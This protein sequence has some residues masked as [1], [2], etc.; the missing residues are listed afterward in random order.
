MNYSRMNVN[1]SIYIPRMSTHWTETTIRQ[2]MEACYIGTVA[3]VDFTPINKKPGFGENVDNVVMSAFV[4]FSEPVLRSD[5]HYYFESRVCDATKAFWTAIQRG[6]PYKMNVGIK[7]YWICLKNKNPIQRTM[8]NIHQ[9][10][11][12]GRYV[13]NLVTT[14]DE[15]IKNLKQTIERQEKA[16]DGLQQVV[17]QLI[18]GLYCQ[19]N[20]SDMINLHLDVL[21]GR[22]PSDKPVKSSIWP[23]TR[24]GDENRE[25]I[26]KLEH[27]IEHHILPEA[28]TRFCDY[29]D[30]DETS[31]QDDELYNIK[32]CVKCGIDLIEDDVEEFERF[33][34]DEEDEEERRQGRKDI[35]EG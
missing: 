35:I 24:Q 23:T 5:G 1:A 30:N 6:E 18:G 3:Y 19:R 14:Q 34:K 31:E 27:F 26:E 33:L 22:E 16:I 11:E 28:T 4:H 2:V 13:E 12:N 9:V 21:Y 32:R 15:E 10:V 29:K 8:M 25:R 20:Q 7:E 17:Y